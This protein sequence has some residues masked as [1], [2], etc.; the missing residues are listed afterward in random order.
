MKSSSKSPVREGFGDEEVLEHQVKRMLADARAE[1]L[2]TDF[3]AQWLRLASIEEIHPEPT[4]FP[5]LYEESCGIDEARG[6]ASVR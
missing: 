1:V 6:R 5:R 4:I 2:A 3:A